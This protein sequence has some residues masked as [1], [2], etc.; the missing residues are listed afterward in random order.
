M[1]RIAVV[2]GGTRGIGASISKA[3]KGAGYTVAATYAGNVQKATAFSEETDIRTYKFDVGHFDACADAIRQITADLGAVEVLVNNAGITRDTFLHKMTPEMWN[4][5]IQADL[6]SLYNMCHAV[7]PAMREANFGRIVNISSVNG[8]KGQMGQTNYAAAKA[9][10]I[11]FTKSLALEV[12]RKG[13]TVNCVAPGYI[14]TDMVAAVPEK[15]L[16]G[17]IAQIPA[18]RLGAAEEIARCVT[19]LA[20]DNA[21]FITGETLNANGGMYMV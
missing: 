15:A 7:V 5:V 13:I 11:G 21:G 12:A 17:I 19:F 8:V 9:G 1:S 20:D 6:S 4:D 18:G 2:T 3:L 16:Q 14:D 10:M